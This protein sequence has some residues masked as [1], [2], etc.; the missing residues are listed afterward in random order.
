[1]GKE[2]ESKEEKEEK[3]VEWQRKVALFLLE[4][5]FASGARN[6]NVWGTIKGAPTA[7]WEVLRQNLVQV[8]RSW[9]CSHVVNSSKPIMLPSRSFPYFYSRVECR[10]CHDRVL[11]VWMLVRVGTSVDVRHLWRTTHFVMRNCKS[12]F[13]FLPKCWIQ[14]VFQSRNYMLTVETVVCDFLWACSWRFESLLC[15]SPP[16][17]P[18]QRE[19]LNFKYWKYGPKRCQSISLN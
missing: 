4:F 15:Q 1:M 17:P 11:P 14:S 12:V 16:P 19:T 2:G 18:P 13:F 7:W 9:P 3:V 10:D 8:R 6:K 5:I